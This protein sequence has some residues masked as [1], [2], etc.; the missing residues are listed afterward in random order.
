M[1][2]PLSVERKSCSIT[3]DYSTEIFSRV[4]GFCQTLLNEQVNFLSNLLEEIQITR[5]S[6][7]RDEL[8]G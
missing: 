8:W 7:V 5:L 2:L 6:I 4:G 1:Y 3:W